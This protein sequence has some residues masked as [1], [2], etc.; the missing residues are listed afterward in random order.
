[1]TSVVDVPQNGQL[2]CELIVFVA[3]RVVFLFETGNVG[4]FPCSII[5]L[6]SEGLCEG[7]CEVGCAS[8]GHGGG[9]RSGVSEA[10]KGGDYPI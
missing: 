5:A 4:G 6:L 8:A 3:Q 7:E 10:R 2:L 1:M 9:G